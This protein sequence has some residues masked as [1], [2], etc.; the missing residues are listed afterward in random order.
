MIHGVINLNLTETGNDEKGFKD[1][2]DY[3]PCNLLIEKRGTGKITAM[4]QIGVISLLPIT[5]IVKAPILGLS[6]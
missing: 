2:M 5:A 1:N 3:V 4:F 6:T